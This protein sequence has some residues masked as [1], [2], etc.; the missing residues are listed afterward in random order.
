M[1]ESD[2]EKND[3]PQKQ[4]PKQHTTLRK[5]RKLCLKLCPA[6]VVKSLLQSGIKKEHGIERGRSGTNV[7]EKLQAKHIK[8]QMPGPVMPGSFQP[9]WLYLSLSHTGLNTFNVSNSEE[10][11]STHLESAFLISLWGYLP[12]YQQWA[13]GKRWWG[14]IKWLSG[15]MRTLPLTLATG[16]W[17]IFHPQ[18]VP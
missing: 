11:Y 4:D 8:H 18:E 10:K 6:P 16:L 5:K 2:S 3:P 15:A 14:S 7:S 9:L 1:I 13:A 17:G 12:R